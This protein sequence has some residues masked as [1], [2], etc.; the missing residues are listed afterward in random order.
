MKMLGNRSRHNNLSMDSMLQVPILKTIGSNNMEKV[1][2]DMLLKFIEENKDSLINPSENNNTSQSDDIENDPILLNIEN[3]NK[4]KNQVLNSLKLGETEILDSLPQNLKNLFDI[5]SLNLIRVG[6][7]QN[8]PKYNNNISVLSSI[9]TCLISNFNLK[10]L[11]EQ[12]EYI[13][14]SIDYI[15]KNFITLFDTEYK[16]L[17]WNKRELSEDLLAFKLHDRTLKVCADTFHI[18]IFIMDMERDTLFFSNTHFVPY[19]K[20]LFLIN[21]K[22]NI[23]ESVFF[24]EKKYVQYNFELITKLVENPNLIKFKDVVTELSHNNLIFNVFEEKLDKYLM[25]K[26]IKL[27]YK[28]KILLRRMGLIKEQVVNNNEDDHEDSDINNFEEEIEDNN[29][30]ENI[31]SISEDENT[32]DNNKTINQNDTIFYKKKVQYTKKDLNLKKIDEIKEIAKEFNIE[33]KSKIDGKVKFKTK[34]QLMEEIVK[35]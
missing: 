20:N 32:S 17:H 31:D 5:N 10:P 8:I 28:D 14:Y 1:T 22:D 30:E 21:L 16:S 11:S 3:I 35:Q 12:I 18:N 33:L 9:L 26:N 29:N 4:K 2:F 23:Y 27:D 6:V 25:I 7:L 15:N 34:S 13:K 19:K 24:N